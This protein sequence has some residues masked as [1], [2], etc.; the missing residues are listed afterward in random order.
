MPEIDHNDEGFHYMVYWK[1]DIP[2]KNWASEDINDWRRSS[3]IIPNQQTFQ[4]Y[5]IKVVAINRRGEANVAS[6]EVIGY[7]GEDSKL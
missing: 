7:S 4:K 5:R 2:E 6:K 1:R 3:L